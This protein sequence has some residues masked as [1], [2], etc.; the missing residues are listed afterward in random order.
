MWTVRWRSRDFEFGDTQS[1]VSLPAGD[2]FIE[3]KLAGETVLSDTVTLD[4]D[5]MY[6]VV[7]VGDNDNQPLGLKVL[8][9]MTAAPAAGS[10]KLRVGH[11][12]PFASDIED[13]KVDICF[14]DGTPL[15]ALQ[16]V[17][18]DLVSDFLEL[19]AGDYDLKITLADNGSCEQTALDLP[20][21]RLGDGDVFDAYAIGKNNEAFPLQAA[22]ILGIQFT[23][24]VNVA[25]FAP[26]GT[27]Q[28]GTAVDVY[29]DGALAIPGL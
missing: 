7:A 10:G 19:P 11:L 21:I 13:T 29:V 14:D 4:P 24:K 5:G 23:S 25:H 17:P 27:D 8:N 9:D 22:T 26:F 3:I 6:S 15:A 16:D 2:R 20:E 28:A 1:G 12:A 18:Y